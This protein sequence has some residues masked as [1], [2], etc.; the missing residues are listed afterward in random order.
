MSEQILESKVSDSQYL[1]HY[2]EFPIFFLTG[3]SKTTLTNKL[4]ATMTVKNNFF[5]K[6][7]YICKHSINFIY[8]FW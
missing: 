1:P 4:G 6:S 3:I 2:Q 8:Y 7:I 5:W